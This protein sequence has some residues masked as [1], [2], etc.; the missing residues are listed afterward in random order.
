MVV[1][2]LCDALL[3]LFIKFDPFSDS[4]LTKDPS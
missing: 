4:P 3:N 1:T 2:Y